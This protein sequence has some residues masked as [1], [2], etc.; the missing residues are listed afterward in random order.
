VESEFCGSSAQNTALN[1]PV[2]SVLHEPE[3]I[4]WLLVQMSAADSSAGFINCHETVTLSI[5]VL[6]VSALD[7]IIPEIDA[8]Q[9]MRT[10]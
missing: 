3:H 5:G 2:A 6:P 7:V 4:D 9:A 8:S 1:E 10:S